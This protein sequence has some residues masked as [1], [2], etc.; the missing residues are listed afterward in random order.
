MLGITKQSL[1]CE[2]NLQ[3]TNEEWKV[4]IGLIIPELVNSQESIAVATRRS[5]A[6]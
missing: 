5:V 3:P 4:L 2:S 6:V 1:H